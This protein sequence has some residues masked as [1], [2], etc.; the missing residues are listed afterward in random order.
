MPQHNWTETQKVLFRIA[1]VFF[2]LMS[3]PTSPEWYKGILDINWTDLHYRDFYDIARFGSG[4]TFFGNEIFGSR[5][6]GYAVWVIT[7]IVS[8]IAGFIWTAV[9]KARKTDPAE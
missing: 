3:I 4:I 9:S 6:N 8:A 7:L 1:F 2:I 5:L